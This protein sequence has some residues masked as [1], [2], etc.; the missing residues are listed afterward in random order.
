MGPYDQAAEGS[1]SRSGYPDVRY[2]E[3]TVLI[4]FGIKR[5]VVESAA[6]R[7]G[8]GV[9]LG[10]SVGKQWSSMPSG[11]RELIGPDSTRN[12][13]LNHCVLAQLR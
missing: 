11:P 1:A 12:K 2:D 6:N 4:H 3:S 5:D 10:E 9:G 8:V 13:V 7:C